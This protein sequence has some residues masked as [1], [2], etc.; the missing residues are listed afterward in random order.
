MQIVLIIVL[1][2][3][4]WFLPFPSDVN[5][6]FFII[7]LK[8]KSMRFQKILEIILLDKSIVS[9][10]GCK[11]TKGKATSQLNKNFIRKNRQSI[12]KNPKNTYNRDKNKVRVKKIQLATVLPN[13]SSFL[14]LKLLYTS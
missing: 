9:K 3:C 14:C 11:R 2:F 6:Y 1:S 4:A 10:K 13:T 7:F 12:L 5:L 8:P